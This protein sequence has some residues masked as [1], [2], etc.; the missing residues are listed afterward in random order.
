MWKTL[1]TFKRR[2]QLKRSLQ[3]MTHYNDQ[4][5]WFV[6]SRGSITFAV[7][8]QNTPNLAVFENVEMCPTVVSGVDIFLKSK[9]FPTAHLK[10]LNWKASSTTGGGGSG[11]YTAFVFVGFTPFSQRTKWNAM[12]FIFQHN[13]SNTLKARESAKFHIIMTRKPVSDLI[14]QSI[15]LRFTFF[16]NKAGKIRLI[17]L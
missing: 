8:L 12:C 17:I 13:S 9:M 5:P 7:F 3:M 2:I 11:K 10:I 16:L 14:W 4:W 1:L 6:S 15:N